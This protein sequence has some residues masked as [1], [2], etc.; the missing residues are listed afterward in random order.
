MCET[1][2]LPI[3]K[4]SSD[5]DN[6]HLWSWVL[7]L[8]WGWFMYFDVSH[9]PPVLEWKLSVRADDKIW[10]R[11]L[12]RTFRVFKYVRTLCV[13]G[14]SD[15]VIAYRMKGGLF[16]PPI[17]NLLSSL[18]ARWLWGK[19]RVERC[20]S[21]WW[22]HTEGSFCFHLYLESPT[23][24]IHHRGLH[25]LHCIWQ[26]LPLRGLEFS[27]PTCHSSTGKDCGM[28]IKASK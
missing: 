20:A 21:S 5:F 24:Q 10:S 6:T 14:V 15:S 3:L 12:V 16:F 4:S 28:W 26:K 11:L 17:I 19:H 9:S 22:I 7:C 27:L 13:N 2:W 18:P 1:H 8:L 25:N 23:S